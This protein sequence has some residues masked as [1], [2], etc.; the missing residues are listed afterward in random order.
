MACRPVWQ[1]K[2]RTSSFVDAF[3]NFINLA[4]TLRAFASCEETALYLWLQQHVY[5]ACNCSF[6]EMA[7]IKTRLALFFHPGYRVVVKQPGEWDALR[8][9]VRTLLDKAV[10]AFF[11][12]VF[13]LLL[14]SRSFQQ[15]VCMCVGEVCAYDCKQHS[16]GRS[17]AMTTEPYHVLIIPAQLL[18]S[19]SC[20]LASVISGVHATI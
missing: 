2:S 1:C 10:C 4:Q 7:I 3:Q 15:I 6:V 5:V 17:I 9:L 20:N 8:E 16:R 12:N 19:A 14:S 13:L 18:K 11:H